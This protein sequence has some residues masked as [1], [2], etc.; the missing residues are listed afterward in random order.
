MRGRAVQGTLAGRLPV[1]RMSLWKVLPPAYAQGLA[2]HP[3][4]APSV[5]HGWHLVR[6]HQAGFKHLVLR[7]VPDHAVRERHFSAG[8]QASVRGELQHGLA[9]QA[10]AATGH[11]GAR[12]QPAAARHGR[13]GRRLSGRGGD[14]RQAW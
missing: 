10:Q 7:H 1:P 12:R 13:D 5:A 14:L 6:Q 3:L 8:S 4:Q 9:G 11:A 2:V